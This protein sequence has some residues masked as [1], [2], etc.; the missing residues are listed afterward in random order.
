MKTVKTYIV[1]WEDDDM[2]IHQEYFQA[3]CAT[4]AVKYLGIPEDKVLEVAVVLKNW[5]GRK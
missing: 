5:K 3:L 1:L 4:D 2:N